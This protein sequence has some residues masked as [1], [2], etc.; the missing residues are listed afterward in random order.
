MAKGGKACDNCG[1]R[2][3]YNKN[4]KM[5]VCELC[6]CSERIVDLETT[7]DWSYFG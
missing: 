4:L 6:G 1:A 5:W 7:G 2:L 3:T